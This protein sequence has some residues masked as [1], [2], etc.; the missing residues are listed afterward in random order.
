MK[1][2]NPILTFILNLC[3]LLS[4]A[5]GSVFTIASTPAYYY[6]QFEVTG[7]YAQVDESGNKIPN[8]LRYIG[9]DS[10][11]YAQFTD[12]Q[13][14]ELIDHIIE[15]L[16]TDMESFELTMDD[17][18]LNG[19][20]TDDVSIFGEVA[21]VHMEDV[22]GLLGVLG[23]IAIVCAVVGAGIIVFFILQ[24]KRGQG[25]KLFKHTLI[26]YGTFVGLVAGFCLF[27]LIQTLAMEIPLEYYLSMVWRNFHFIIFPDPEKAMGSFF[28]DTLTMILSLDLFMAAVVMVLCIIALAVGLWLVLARYLDALSRKNQQIKAMPEETEK[29]STKYPIIMAHG[30]LM[31]I[32]LFKAFKYLQKKLEAKGYTVYIANTDGVGTIENNAKQLKKE[33][34]E[35]LEKEGVDK[36][37]I[38]AHSKGGLDSAYMIEELGMAEH[39]ASLTSLCTPYKGSQLATRII[40]LP[41]FILRFLGFWFNAFYRLLK[42]EQP[43]VLMACKQLESKVEI[44]AE[45]LNGFPDIYFQSYSATMYKAMD[46]FVLSIPFLISRHYENENSDGMVGNTSAQMGEYKGSCLDESLSHNEIVCF[47]TKKKKKEKVLAFYNTL[48]EDLAERGL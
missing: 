36:V 1:I 40:K 2:V 22:K 16:F 18:L 3:I 48:L 21:V 12:E 34:E 35:I 27:T 47:L 41:S 17:V 9:G 14:N 25:G 19:K 33:I 37:N 30:I 42:D 5:V 15:Y 24:A 23:T 38:I 31:K 32:P 10:D 7:V 8:T 39:V 28:N 11:Q 20:I 44:M 26:F 13:L 43:D 45:P 4:V 29:K 6:N 46:D